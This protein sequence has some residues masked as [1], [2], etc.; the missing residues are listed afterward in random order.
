VCWERWITS[1]PENILQNLFT[2]YDECLKVKWGQIQ[3]VRV[4]CLQ[5][6][7]IKYILVERAAGQKHPVMFPLQFCSKYCCTIMSSSFHLIWKPWTM[8]RMMNRFTSC[9]T[10]SH[11]VLYPATALRNLF[12]ASILL[13]VNQGPAVRSLQHCG[14]SQ[15]F[16]KF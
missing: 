11:V 1:D 16:I 12:I 5:E 13:S 14:Y 10:V 4:T 8:S 15:Y 7:I 9:L 2:Y 3:Y 6:S